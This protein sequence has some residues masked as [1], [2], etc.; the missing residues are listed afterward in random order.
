[1]NNNPVSKEHLIPA[2]NGAYE[3]SVNMGSWG[4]HQLG[5]KVLG[6]VSTGTLTV[7]AKAPG[8]DVFEIVPDGVI[9]LTAITT[10]LFTFVAAEYEFTLA[11]VTGATSG[12]QVVVTDI[13]M[14]I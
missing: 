10:V 4:N 2:A 14:G 13:P 12:A 5:I 6:S 7:K 11:S 1:M 8:S 9:D 3:R